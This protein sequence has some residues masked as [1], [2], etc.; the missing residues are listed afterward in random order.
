MISYVINRILEIMGGT[1]INCGTRVPMHFIALIGT[2]GPTPRT[3]PQD[4]KH[5]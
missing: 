1:P 3:N 2:R 4:S 5:L